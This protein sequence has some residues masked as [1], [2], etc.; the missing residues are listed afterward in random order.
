M[1][2]TLQGGW[3]GASR[4][5]TGTGG[6]G[7]AGPSSIRDRPASLS[8]LAATAR[9]RAEAEACSSA[10]RDLAVEAP[11]P[12]TATPLRQG[13]LP[14]RDAGWEGGDLR[15]R[16]GPPSPG[17]EP[18]IQEEAHGL[19][20]RLSSR[21]LGRPARQGRQR[22]LLPVLSCTHSGSTEERD[23]AASG[24]RRFRGGE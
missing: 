16:H 9:P 18:G 3:E 17:R 23:T 7:S 5:K 8:I 13:S 10:S 2:R 14:C 21:L 12:C 1:L 24:E 6:G 19:G 15:H 22:P 11:Y 4:H 20:M